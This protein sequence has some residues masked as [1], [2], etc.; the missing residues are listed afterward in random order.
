MRQSARSPRE[1]GFAETGEPVQE[2]QLGHSA[3]GG[4]LE[5][6]P[7]ADEGLRVTGA[8]EVVSG[9]GHR[10]AVRERVF[11]CRCGLSKTK[12]FCDSSHKAAGFVAPG[13]K[14]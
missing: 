11:L 6:F 2:A 7:Q 12:P 5:D 10:I 8:V 4:P 9:T 13:P 3:R 1:A 14:T